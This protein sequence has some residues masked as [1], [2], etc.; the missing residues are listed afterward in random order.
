[1]IPPRRCVAAVAMVVL[2]GGEALLSGCSLSKV[3]P[4]KRQDYKYSRETAPLELPPDI[5]SSGDFTGKTPFAVDTSLPVDRVEASRSAPA[6]SE[7]APARPR[8]PIAETA[9]WVKTAG[10]PAYI[11]VAATPNEVWQA[12]GSAIVAAKMKIVEKDQAHDR[13]KIAFREA[14]ESDDGEEGLFSQIKGIFGFNTE[15]YGEFYVAVEPEHDFSKVIMLD[16]Q[17]RRSSEAKAFVVL[18]LIHS[19]LVNPS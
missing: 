15:S 16:R 2:T 7:S 1:M 6:P 13:Y 17:G 14:S 12:V 9:E 10:E 3:F 4:D 19:K 5:L 11:R 18:K 8:R